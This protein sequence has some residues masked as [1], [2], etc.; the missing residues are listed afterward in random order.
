MTFNYNIQTSKILFE[1]TTDIK[2]QISVDLDLGIDE[3]GFNGPLPCPVHPLTPRV[4]RPPAIWSWPESV[5]AGAGA[6]LNERSTMEPCNHCLEVAL[7]FVDICQ[8][9]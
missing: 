7:K 4:P 9:G 8:R 2:V 6:A 1:Y 5:A 3:S